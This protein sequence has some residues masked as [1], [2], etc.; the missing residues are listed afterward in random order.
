MRRD[1]CLEGRRTFRRAETGE[2]D[3]SSCYGS[4][5]SQS[6]VE[7]PEGDETALI[8]ANGRVAWS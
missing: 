3:E 4:A 7:A 6:A 8:V 2:G 5:G 1:Q